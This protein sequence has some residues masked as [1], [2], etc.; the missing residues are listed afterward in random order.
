MAGEGYCGACEEIALDMIF[1]PTGQNPPMPP[2]HAGGL[3][4]GCC[5]G[6]DCMEEIT[7]ADD[8]KTTRV[9]KNIG[10]TAETATM[11]EFCFDAAKHVCVPCHPKT[12]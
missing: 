2:F 7:L 12:R 6:A 10:E 9:I 1:I 3:I 5:S 11:A 8:F 4:C